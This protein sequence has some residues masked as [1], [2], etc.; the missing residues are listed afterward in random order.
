M[1]RNLIF[2]IKEYTSPS[3]DRKTA[4]EAFSLLK[5][6]DYEFCLCL[7]IMSE[8]LEMSQIVS[9]ALQS[10]ELDVPSAVVL[11]Q[12]LI[13]EISEKRNETEFTKYWNI[14]QDTAKSIGVQYREP[15]RRKIS[16]RI[17]EYWHTEETQQTGVDSLRTALY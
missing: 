4:G 11:I 9:K 10:K 7:S 17:D 12:G 14:A 8:L 6:I 3:Y 1:V 5:S 15:R 16:K 2:Y 13:K